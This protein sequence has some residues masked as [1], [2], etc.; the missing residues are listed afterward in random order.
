MRKRKAFTL[1]EIL[2]VVAILAILTL[3]VIA[4]YSGARQK[5]KIDVVTDTLISVLKEKQSN[6]KNGKGGSGET[7]LCYGLMFQTAGSL[8]VQELQADYFS[9]NPD[10][11]PNKADFCDTRPGYLTQKQFD[12]ME[13]YK[14]KEINAFGIDKDS[15]VIMFRPPEGRISVGEDLDNV[16]A[17]ENTNS[18]LL[19]FTVESANGLD[20][21]SFS[22]DVT[23]GVAE[24]LPQ[25]VTGTP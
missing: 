24:K 4:N 3:T 16:A 5:A 11:N 12:L 8:Y 25:T 22:F 14:I 20:K 17:M 13:D 15:Y 23:S 18:P 9:V 1:I 7:S 2:I 19:I 21:E 6:S 10:I